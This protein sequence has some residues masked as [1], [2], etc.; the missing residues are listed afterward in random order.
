MRRGLA[1][2][3]VKPA[4]HRARPVAS[5]AFVVLLTIAFWAGAVWLAELL[6]RLDRLGY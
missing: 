2:V 4:A 3:G 1:L 6:I 5:L